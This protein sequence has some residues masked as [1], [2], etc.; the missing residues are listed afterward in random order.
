MTP[1]K[2]SPGVGWVE[3]GLP[4]EAHHRRLL[5]AANLGALRSPRRN[6]SG[7][8][9]PATVRSG[10]TAACMGEAM[11]RWWVSLGGPRSTHPTWETK[12][13]ADLVKW[14]Q[15]GRRSC[16]IMLRCGFTLMEI[17]L[18]LAVVGGV[19]LGVLGFY[20]SVADSRN[21]IIAYAEG[22]GARR[23]VMEMLTDELRGALAYR[24]LNLG[25]EG[26]EDSILFPTTRIPGPAVWI[27]RELTDQP[28][29]PEHD[30]HVVGYR[31]ALW[32]R[33]DGTVYVAGLERTHQQVV[34]AQAPEEGDEIIVDFVTGHVRF[35]FF[36]YHDGAQWQTSWTGGDLPAA[37]RITLGGHVLPEEIEPE[38]YP[39][40]ITRRTVFIPGGITP[41]AGGMVQRGAMR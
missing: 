11:W 3:R 5:F 15:G 12:G 16:P 22:I 14:S 13:G 6:R 31:P 34:T 2:T 40:P 29:P 8:P 36:E 19:I 4:S 27:D 18:A 21:D 33:E 9:H 24:F 23:A 30:L 39:H 20:R 10:P 38:D 17:L 1:Y 37:V 32:E 35:I 41:Q 26:T 28:I 7:Q 25:V